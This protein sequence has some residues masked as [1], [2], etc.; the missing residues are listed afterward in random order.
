MNTMRSVKLIKNGERKVP[1]IQAKVESAADPNRWPTAVQSW[2]SEF[3]Q[4]RRGE[5]L[6]A[7]NSLFK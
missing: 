1:E 7:F 5:I 4:H 6:P 3:Q 2:V